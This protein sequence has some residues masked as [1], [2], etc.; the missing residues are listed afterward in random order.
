MKEKEYPVDRSISEW[1]E[2]ND[3]DLREEVRK[4]ITGFGMGGSTAHHQFIRDYHETIV[5][6]ELKKK[7]DRILLELMS[8]SFRGGDR[9]MYIATDLKLTGVKEELIASIGK[10]MQLFETLQPNPSME[11]WGIQIQY[12]LQFNSSI[13]QLNIK[14]AR[15]LLVKQL[16][17]LQGPLPSPGPNKEYYLYHL[18][19][20]ALEVL[21]KIDPELARK[22]K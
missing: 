17:P 19:K 3:E 18:A 14:E 15:E 10:A 11:E 22:Y 1:P 12:F 13:L 21:K 6:S 8:D 16:G 5:G 2:L 20:S 9:A 4:S 7:V